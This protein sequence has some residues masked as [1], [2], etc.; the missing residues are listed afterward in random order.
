MQQQINCSH[1]VN[2]CFMCLMI[3]DNQFSWQYGPLLESSCSYPSDRIYMNRLPNCQTCILYM[4]TIYSID[5]QHF[6]AYSWFT[7]CFQ[8][9]KIN[10]WPSQITRRVQ[11][12]YRISM[13]LL[14]QFIT[15]S[16][17]HSMLFT[18]V[19]TALIKP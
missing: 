2:F 10:S 9:I 17:K 18:Q 5:G 8:S 4:T 14:K 11:H 6:S 12:C 19:Y 1:H 16:N 15:F 13:P 7:P 3:W